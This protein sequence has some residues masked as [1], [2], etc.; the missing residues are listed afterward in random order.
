MT[1]D[2]LCTIQKGMPG[3]SRGQKRIAN[4]ILQSY[5]KA[6]FMTASRL[7]KAVQVSEST[8]VRFAMEIGYD[9]Y[10]SMQRAL[11]EMIRSKL[12]SLQRIEVADDLIGEQDV[13]SLVFRSD[14]ERL[15]MTLDQLDRAEFDAAV[16][17]ILNA[18]HIYIV[19]LRSSHAI[20]RFL[21]FYFQLIFQNV[22]VVTT[23]AVGDLYEQ[24]IRIGREDVLIG[25]SFPRY[26][27]VTLGV[28]RWAAEQGA[29]VIALTDSP[30]SPITQTARYTLLAKSDMLSFIDSLV[31]P[32]SL[33]NALIVSVSR[34]KKGELNETL[35]SLE[36]LWSDYDVYEKIEQ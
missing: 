17:A 32:L 27:T 16:Q 10:P 26:S 28:S 7:G 14:I 20:A 4:Y 9:G 34:Y 15:H 35:A 8:V 13:L 29:T 3:F 25:I 31:A 5:D 36:Q 21:G 18:R 24:V 23:S 22:T 30:A 33:V 11:Q 1:N 12:T 6:A 2:I 19:G